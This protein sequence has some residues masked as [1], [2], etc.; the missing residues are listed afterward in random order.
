MPSDPG[1]DKVIRRL[2]DI[3]RNA[4]F[5]IAEAEGAGRDGFIQSMTVQYAVRYAML[6][7]SEAA[8]HLPDDLISGHAEISDWNKLKGIGNPLRHEYDRLDPKILWEAATVHVPRALKAAKSMLA[9][10]AEAPPDSESE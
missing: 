1:D 2:N 9:A 7:M 5:V 8:R 4:E 3:V 10:V 6:C